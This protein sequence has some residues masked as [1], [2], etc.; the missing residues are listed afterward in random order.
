MPRFGKGF[1][2]LFQSFDR[3][4]LPTSQKRFVD[5]EAN[6]DLEGNCLRQ[7][8]STCAF[9]MSALSSTLADCPMVAAFHTGKVTTEE[10]SN[11]KH[12]K[13]LVYIRGI[14]AVFNLCYPEAILTL[15]YPTIYTH[16][17][18]INIYICTSVYTYTHIVHNV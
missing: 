12:K 14:T 1:V 5:V 2:F 10:T 9:R 7:K 13:L 4:F 17:Y 8:T 11:W 3:L 18:N 16:S 6:P 15:K